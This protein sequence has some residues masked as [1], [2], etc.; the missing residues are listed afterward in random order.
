MALVSTNLPGHA[1]AQGVHFA[2]LDGVT[3]IRV[4][5][6]RA[7]LQGGKLAL[8]AEAFLT[9]FTTYRAVYE[10]VAT[11]KFEGGDFKGSMSITLDD[12]AKFAGKR[13]QDPTRHSRAA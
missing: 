5:V 4:I 12:L 7:A 9:Q 8:H 3:T 1:N 10:V 2:M 11:Q 13:Q 6:T